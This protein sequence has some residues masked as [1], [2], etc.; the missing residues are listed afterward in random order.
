[1][2]SF[3]KCLTILSFHLLL[4]TSQED[5]SS[6]G[7]FLPG[8]TST[9]QKIL[10]NALPSN[11]NIRGECKDIFDKT[12]L[13]E[14]T[15]AQQFVQ[16]LFSDS[17]KNKNDFLTY[18]SCMFFQN[19]S[20]IRTTYLFTTISINRTTP[21]MS[22]DLKKNLSKYFDYPQRYHF[23]LCVPSGCNET[24]YTL[25]AEQILNNNKEL[26]RCENESRCELNLFEI[27]SFDNKFAFSPIKLISL[28]PLL[29]II[30]Q[31]ILNIFPV[32]PYWLT[33]KFAQ[34]IH[35]CKREKSSLYKVNV[36]K[37]TFLR[38]KKAFSIAENTDELFNT[39]KLNSKINN[40]TGLTYIKGLRVI[41]MMFFLLGTVFVMII[42]S[43]SY[44]TSEASLD[45][46]MKSAW[47]SFILFGIRYAPRILLSCSGF[48]L[49]YKFMCF[50]D[51]QVDENDEDETE[52]EDSQRSSQDNARTYSDLIKREKEK[53]KK[54]VNTRVSNVLSKPRFSNGDV[55]FK[56]LG[57]FI[58]YQFHKYIITFVIIFFMKWSLYSIFI[59]V[60]GSS[61]LREY[62]NQRIIQQST[63]IRSII[64]QLILIRPFLF[65][66]FQNTNNEMLNGLDIFYD[67]YWLIF[68][69][70]IFFLASS[71]IIFICYKE[72][73]SLP[74]FCVSV[75]V[76]LIILRV[77]FLFAFDYYT[78]HYFSHLNYGL[79][80]ICP[81]NNYNFYLIGIYFGLI[82]YTFQKNITLEECEDTQRNYLMNIIH[83]IT[84]QQKNSKTCNNI[85]GIFIF[86]ITVLASLMQCII[87]QVTKEKFIEHPV[88]NVIYA[89]DLE[90]VIYLLHRI[91]FAFYL[92]G[93]NIIHSL[94]CSL[95]WE[96]WNKLYFCFVLSLPSVL[97][98][99]LYQSDNRISLNF[100][101]ILYYSLNILVFNTIV[102]CLLY[103]LFELPCKRVV[104]FWMKLNESSVTQNPM[105]ELNSSPAYQG[106]FNCIYDDDDEEEEN[107]NEDDEDPNKPIL[108]NII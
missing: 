12:L 31:V 14:K 95:K 21:E 6:E 66:N 18:S 38:I 20:D 3:I 24:E 34:L 41:A 78:F 96:F 85:F 59:L 103:V 106:D 56:F 69:E 90:L 99:F 104:K 2:S 52:E 33:I 108:N 8:L 93:N 42:Q 84:S 81:L 83:Y 13:A 51:D 98:F 46:L 28:L 61:P 53:Q 48:S 80:F 39:R 73:Y 107:E 9:T 5:F 17:S 67:Y 7:Y 25:I 45:S 71:F 97:L 44:I 101:T 72:K 63:R 94:A 4:V 91:L 32:I 60:E 1:M 15:K 49:T 43:P 75:G 10:D 102:A 22:D 79:Y 16:K 47:F 64:L 74:F 30:I 26:F 82:N 29:I 54:T 57:S 27:N 65:W 11:E 92:K 87:L 35:K 105:I 40:E 55:L 68:N 37:K 89:I 36:L 50:L 100:L 19:N 76:I 23:G 58:K 62:Y 88:W 70:M 86:I 77:I